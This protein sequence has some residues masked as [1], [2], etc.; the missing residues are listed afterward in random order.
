MRLT[1]SIGVFLS[2]DRRAQRGA[3]RRF[4][5][6]VQMEALEADVEET[7]LHMDFVCHF[8]SPSS[9]RSLLR[10]EPCQWDHPALLALLHEWQKRLEAEK[11][12]LSLL[13]CIKHH[14]TTEISS[15]DPNR[16]LICHFMI[17]HYSDR[18]WKCPKF[19]KAFLNHP[20]SYGIFRT[21]EVERAPPT[22]TQ[23]SSTES[24]KKKLAQKWWT[25]CSIDRWF[26]ENSTEKPQEWVGIK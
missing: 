21:Q 11:Q 20:V 6:G 8:P 9:L 18:T 22:E 1:L 19:M 13:C 12:L 4:G 26:Q 7:W 16:S 10:V 14:L 24:P 15:F 3:E 17:K 23:T 2:A 5:G 25:R